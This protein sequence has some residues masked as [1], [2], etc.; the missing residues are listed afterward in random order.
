MIV[1]S[2]APS[3]IALRLSLSE[4]IA[5]RLEAICAEWN[6]PGA[7]ALRYVV[8][9]RDAHLFPR[10]RRHWERSLKV[11]AS[12]NGKG[13]G[14]ATWHHTRARRDQRKERDWGDT[15]GLYRRESIDHRYRNFREGYR[16]FVGW[17]T[18]GTTFELVHPSFYLIYIMR[19]PDGSRPGSPQDVIQDSF[20]LACPFVA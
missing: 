17:T 19:H 10:D 2:R 18:A 11:I 5:E 8:P 3:A 4:R 1:C 6:P 20:L 14:S 15:A 16:N 7:A 13:E 12:K 9:I